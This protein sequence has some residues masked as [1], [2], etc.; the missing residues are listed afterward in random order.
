MK[1]RIFL[2]LCVMIISAQIYAQFSIKT[3]ELS[4]ISE[5]KKTINQE[6]SLQTNNASVTQKNKFYLG[7][8]TSLDYCHF[9]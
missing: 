8:E 4:N 1:R 2:S 6:N 5:N 9:K 7:I 3:V